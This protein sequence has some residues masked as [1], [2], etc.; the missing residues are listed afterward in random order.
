MISNNKKLLE[1]LMYDVEGRTKTFFEKSPF[2]FQNEKGIL[3][4]QLGA[5]LVPW[6]E[7][8][9]I[10]EDRGI[11]ITGRG[12]GKSTI[13][14]ELLGAD[15][16]CFLPYFLQIIHGEKAPVP[17]DI[18][19]VANVKKNARKRLENAKRYI[20][21]NA[22]LEKELVDKTSWTK[23]FSSL[24]NDA[25]MIAEGASDNARGAHKRHK[26]GKVIY[27]L[28][29]QAFWGGAQCQDSKE[30]V[31]NI[32]ERS[33]GAVIMGFTTPYGK[34]GGAWHFWNH[35]DWLKWHVPSWAN[36]YQDRVK[37]ARDV[38]RLLSLGRGLVVD[39]EIRGLFVDDAGLF[40][41]ADTWLKAVNPSLEWL[42]EYTGNYQSLLEQVKSVGKR[43]GDY[44]L[45]IDPNKGI[46]T[47]DGDPIGI[48]L[49]EKV[50]K[51]KYINR[52]TVAI[53]GKTEEELEPLF[54]LFQA[55]LNI[56][57]IHFD[58][59]GG[60]WKGLY[61]RFKALGWSNMSL[62]NPQANGVVE[63]MSNLRAAM[64]MDRYQMPESEDLKQSQM[65]MK[66]FGETDS[67]SESEIT[68]KVKFQTDGKK[69]GIPC[70]LCAMGLSMA[71]ERFS[72]QN[73]YIVP[74]KTEQIKD[75]PLVHAT[76][77]DN[78]AK[79]IGGNFAGIETKPLSVGI[80]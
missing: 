77:L 67:E 41:S 14:Q 2:R 16:A 35:P 44:F 60:Y 4:Y 76:T 79:I 66:G 69:S 58:A 23:E 55:N 36:P 12:T 73:D 26:H 20:T 47:K 37:L 30:F 52:F 49:T 62:I 5:Y 46:R 11:M 43:P 61:T 50:S 71:K 17:V 64:G 54:R 19:F 56:K 70:D 51:Y 9:G 78:Y 65:S 27:L 1:L 24:R 80:N 6:G 29:E 15:L 21:H 48:N 13:M 3:G 7:V 10:K 72:F 59:G 39:Q 40:F 38:A 31:E 34:R 32:A 75:V 18:I 53:N 42:Y 68:G 63:Y 28:E 25:N 74:G 33:M 22:Y 45:G 8:Y 57:R